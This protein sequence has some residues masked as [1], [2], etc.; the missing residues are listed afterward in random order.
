MPSVIPYQHLWEKDF[1]G[2]SDIVGEHAENDRWR[3]RKGG[4]GRLFV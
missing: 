3:L 1:K 4:Q 2:D